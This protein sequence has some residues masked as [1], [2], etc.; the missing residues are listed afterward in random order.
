[1]SNPFDN[2]LFDTANPGSP[3]P[4]LPDSGPLDTVQGLQNPANFNLQPFQYQIGNV[5]FGLG[6][7]YPVNDIDVET[8]NIN[9]QDF[10]VIRTDE[11]QFGIDT[12]APG[13]ITFKMAV[14]D[15]RPLPN[16]LGLTNEELPPSLVAR[17][18][19]LLPQLAKEWK[20]NEV[21]PVW[22]ETKPI[23][24]CDADGETRRI[25][26]RPRKFKYS[27]RTPKNAYFDVQAE[28][29]RADTYAYSDTEYYIGPIAPNGPTPVFASRLNG[30]GDAWFR[31]LLFGPFTDPSITFGENV[32]NLNLSL[33]DGVVLE[34]SSYP[35]ERR[36]VDSNGN[37]W[38]ATLNGQIIYL[39]QMIFY[40]NQVWPVNWTTKDGT[41][42]NSDT[43]LVFLWRES[44]HVI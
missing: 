8:Y 7:E 38:R 44:F 30:N 39:D 42:T 34:I 11:R 28:Y 5:V 20:A 14:L 29:T 31:L 36:I 16:I 4:V 27:R 10:Q 15:N 21:R 25:Y 22:G 32:L 2:P 13:T 24:F 26:G 41:P 43:Q 35:W 33:N 6:T 3:A 37:N 23:L 18:G 40:D 12:L 17:Q 19:V 9:Q 1:M